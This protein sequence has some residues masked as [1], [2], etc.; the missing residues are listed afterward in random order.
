VFSLTRLWITGRP[1]WQLS[2]TPPP[3]IWE[4]GAD[5]A[6]F[7]SVAALVLF[8][9][10]AAWAYRELARTASTAAAQVLSTRSE[11]TT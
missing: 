6:F 11:S 7:G 10:G 9:A 3:L 5:A 2:P 8:T 4:T 1:E